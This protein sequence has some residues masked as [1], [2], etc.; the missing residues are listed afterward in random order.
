MNTTLKANKLVAIAVAGLILLTGSAIGQQ[1]ADA[2]TD[3]LQVTLET[4]KRFYKLNEPI[5]LTFS[6]KNTGTKPIYLPP[7]S[8]SL[9]QNASEGYFEIQIEANEEGIK[10]S[11]VMV[12]D[13][14]S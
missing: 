8:L 5:L 6:V 11:G 13:S 10:E 4:N 3:A 1:V 7:G 2:K 14:F 12:A 9:V